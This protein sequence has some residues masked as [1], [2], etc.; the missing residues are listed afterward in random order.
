MVAVTVKTVAK[1]YFVSVLLLA[2]L[3]SPL[4]Q[5]AL[6]LVLLAIQLGLT[7][8][9]PKGNIGLFLVFASLIFA[10]LTF[11]A[12]AGG[13]FAVL[14]TVPVLLLLD[15]SLKENAAGQ[16]FVFKRVGR[17]ASDVLKIF[18][19][20][21]VIVFVASAFL[22]NLTLMLTITLIGIYFV[23]VLSGVFRKIS[24]APF[25]ESKTWKRIVVGET[26][27][28][29]FP[30]KTKCNVPIF[31]SLSSA[32]SWVKVE[33]SEFVLPSGSEVNVTL[34]FTPPLAGP[35]KILLRAL[36]VDSRGLIL[37]GQNLEPLD[38]HIIPRAHYA[39]WLA[40]KYLE[41]TASGSSMVGSV[42]S[43]SSGK[44]A[45]KGVEYYGSREY[46]PGDKW[47]NVDWKHT[48]LFGKLIVKEFAGA[49]GQNAILI[50]DLTA[51]DSEEADKLAFDLVMSAYTF[52]LE[53][54]PTALAV[55]NC[56]GVLAMSPPLNP[57]DALKKTLQLTEKIIVIAPS[58]K[59]LEPTKMR[60]I[61]RSISQLEQSKMDSSQ[62]LAEVL[63]LEYEANQKTALNDP[64]GK[65]LIKTV[66][67]ILPPATI[68]VVSSS[69][70]N[71]NILN[72]LLE[73]VEDKGYNIIKTESTPTNKITS[74]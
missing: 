5:L 8:R 51:K 53:S 2:I 41:R 3:V 25:E 71:E 48:Y 30:L 66:E 21:A 68:T 67:S 42:V 9:Q 10:P 13:V 1:V 61:R 37:T 54:L 26:A 35:S 40:L 62:R 60:K 17:S 57:R 73:K 31:V 50:A 47:K 65:A 7:Y 74:I 11:S 32:V 63:N 29:L 22:W 15:D 12:I 70:C 52:A 56:D 38:L 39:R 44:S 49:Q 46:Q 28:N 55:Y 14:L 72:V 18:S 19:A 69:S 20:A 33:Q 4:P 59:V 16:P 45:K 36:T 58:E 6:A 64:I 27:R 34:S 24:R 23:V 43:D